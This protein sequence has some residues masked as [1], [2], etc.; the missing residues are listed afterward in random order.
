MKNLANFYSPMKDASGLLL[1]TDIYLNDTVDSII[2]KLQ[3][4]KLKYPSYDYL[5]LENNST[6]GYCL[7]GYIKGRLPYV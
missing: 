5:Q 3:A 2:D 4:Y 7:V 1:E 6:E